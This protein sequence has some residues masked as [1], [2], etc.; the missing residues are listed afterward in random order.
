MVRALYITMQ[1]LIVM[2]DFMSDLDDVH[3]IVR[4]PHG[5]CDGYYR[6]EARRRFFFELLPQCLDRI[7]GTISVLEEQ[8]GIIGDILDNYLPFPNP[9][10]SQAKPDSSANITDQPADAALR[11]PG[12]RNSHHSRRSQ[13]E[14]PLPIA[15]RGTSAWARATAMEGTMTG[16]LPPRR[17][18]SASSLLLHSASAAA[19]ASGYPYSS[20]LA[21]PFLRPISRFCCACTRVRFHAIQQLVR[22]RF[23][24]SFTYWNLER[25]EN[26]LE[27]LRVDDGHEGAGPFCAMRYT[28]QG[29]AQDI[30]ARRRKHIG[31]ADT[32]ERMSLDSD[33]WD[34]DCGG[35]AGWV[36]RVLGPRGR[37]N[38]SGWN[39]EEGSNSEEMRRLVVVDRGEAPGEKRKKR[40]TCSSG[41]ERR[42]KEERTGER[43]EK[44]VGC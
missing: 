28:V 27:K 19:A 14:Q 33:G 32:E 37:K 39:A 36:S 9:A 2:R 16:G 44:L 25:L 18:I 8:A 31:I 5:E 24:D 3:S 26:R 6:A 22:F 38:A 13:P 10:A 12:N 41:E 11:Q 4:L 23:L 20:R 17:A 29:L 34:R 43:V 30:I 1:A 15:H 40:S 7:E 42:S 35:Q 21:H